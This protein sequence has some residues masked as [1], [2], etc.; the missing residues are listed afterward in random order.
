MAK[1]EHFF[2]DSSFIKHVAWESSKKVLTITFSS[3]SIW[4][5]NKV[6]KTKY[7]ALCRSKSIGAYFNKNIRN[8]CEGFP[9]ARVGESSIIIYSREGEEIVQ[10]KQETQE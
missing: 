1:H 7:N 2:V 6:S 4:Y 9:I 3:G 8:K 5:Y 10:K